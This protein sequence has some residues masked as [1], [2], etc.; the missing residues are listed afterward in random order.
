MN[1]GI[2]LACALAAAAVAATFA[3]RAGAEAPQKIDWQVG[4]NYTVLARPQATSVAPGKVEVVEVFWYGCSHCYSLDPALENW[5]KS[6]PGY[7]EFVRVPVIWGLGHQQHARL[8]YTLQVLGRGD[9]HP[10]V[11]DAIHRDG[12]MLSADTDAQAR[13]LQLAFLK[14]HGVTDQQFNAAYSSE[15]VRNE[16]QRAQQLTYRYEVPSVPTIVVNGTYST[17]VSQAGSTERLLSLIND[18]A[19]RER[20]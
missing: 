9:L 1:R 15:Q 3:V 11:F 7:I 18:L 13:A 5:K 17:S 8:F 20:P 14:K 12:V 6:K 2:V 16:V 19:A 4:T 10:V